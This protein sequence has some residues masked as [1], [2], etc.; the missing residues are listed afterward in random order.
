[1]KKTK[2]Y[3]KKTLSVFMAIMM[4][5]TAWVF[6]APEK[7]E[8]GSATT[9]AGTNTTKLQELNGLDFGTGFTTVSGNFHGDSA[10]ETA[11]KGIFKN[12]LY[13]PHFPASNN[14]LTNNDAGVYFGTLG[15]TADGARVWYPETT[16]IW[17]GVTTP[18]I[19]ILFDIDSNNKN[20]VGVK[21]V[22]I[23]S[24]ANGLSFKDAYW[25]AKSECAKDTNYYTHFTFNWIINNN[26]GNYW[27]STSSGNDK[28]SMCSSKGYWDIYATYLQYTGGSFGSGSTYYKDIKPTWV[29]RT[30]SNY[31]G[32]TNKTIYVIDYVPLKN[33]L[34]SV[35]GIINSINSNP[36][37]YTT[38]SV[39]AFVDAAK[40]LVAAK[41]NNYINAN[42]NNVYEWNTAVSNALSAWNSAK[43]LAVQ[44][45]TL[46]FRNADNQ[47]VHTQTSPYG[48]SVD[49][50]SIV[51]RLGT[52]IEQIAGNNAEHQTYKWD[53]SKFVSTITDDV[54]ISETPTGKVAHNYGDYTQTTENHSRTCSVCGYVFTQNHNEDKGTLDE[55]DTCTEAGRKSYD[56]TIC[57][58]TD[59]RTEVV[60]SIKGH[61]FS[62]AYLENAS[63]KDGTHWQECIRFD[64]CK[65]YGIGTTANKCEKHNWDKDNSGT[66][67]AGDAETKASTCNEAG[68]EMYTCKVCSATWTKV[69]P[70]ADHSITE[71]KAKD[72]SNICGADGYKAFWTC[73]VCDRVWED[74]DLSKEIL[75]PE[76]TVVDG[77]SVPKELVVKGP[78][79][80]FIGAYVSVK[81]G[82]D[83]KH[84]RQCERFTQC[85][86]YG[87]EE[88][89]KFVPTVT[90]STCIKAGKTTYTCSDC[91]SKYEVAL[92]LA[93]HDMTK[94]DAV[95]AECGK[96]GSIEYYNCSVC[97][98][99]YSDA[100]GKNEVNNITVPAL[101]H[102]FL[103]ENDII[104]TEAELLVS[105]ATCQKAAVYKAKCDHCGTVS[106]DK[107]YSVGDPDTVN[108]HKFDGAI[109]KNT[110]GTHSYKCTVAGCDEYGAA[111]TC[112]FK[113][114]K[115]KVKSTC[116]TLGYTI[117]E[118]TT[119]KAE[120]RVD[121]KALDFTNH[122]GE[123]EIRAAVEAKCN[124]NG[125]TGDTYCLGCG[126]MIKKGEAIIAD[127]T[128]HPHV[129]MKDYE[130]KPSTCQDA[131]Y[132]AYK[133]CD[134]CRTYEIEKV[135][136]TL[137][138]HKFTKYVT[139]NDG[140][141]TAV[142]DTCDAEVAEP[143]TDT[144]DC[145]GGTANCVDKKVCTVCNAPYGEV[146]ATNHKTVKTAEK[147]E[148]TCQ[149]E[150]TV[151]YRYCEACKV[152]IEKPETIAKKPHIFGAWSKIEGEDKHTRSCTTCVD[153][154]KLDIATETKDC[155]G[156]TAYCNALAKCKDCKAEYG[157]LDA[158][159]H[160][161][162]ANYLDGAY[163]A[164]CQKEGFTGNYL[165]ECCNALKQ[166]GTT[167]PKKDHVFDIEVENSR[168]DATCIAEGEVTYKCSTCVETADVKAATDKKVLPVN[169]NNH[170]TPDETVVVGKKAA[171]C[172]ED[173]HTGDVYYK[174]C[175]KEGATD[176]ENRKALKEKGTT[177][178]ANGQHVYGEAIP[179]YMIER[180]DETKDADGNVTSR[181]IV[182]KTK[183]PDYDA[184]VDARRADDKWY[185]F[186]QCTICGVITETACYTY[187]HTYN[188]VDTDKCEVCKGLCSLKDA[189][190][191]I[192]LIK[193]DQVDATHT[194]DGTKAYYQCKGCK[195]YFL[196]EAGKNE[197]NPATEEG[198]ALIA[199]SKDTV[200]CSK[201]EEIKSEYVAPTCGKDG[202]KVYS[203]SIEGCTKTIVEV[204]PAT[205][206]SHEWGTEYE[207]IKAP[208]CG[209]VGYEALYCT[210]CDAIK[211][212]STVTI[213][214]T[215]EH[216]F[217]LESKVEG[218]SCK[219]PSIETYKCETCGKTKTETV[220]DGAAD[221]TWSDWVTIGGDCASGIIQERECT[222]CGEKER[223]SESTDAHIY[224]LVLR[225][226]PTAEKDGYEIYKCANCEIE[227]R[228]EIPYEG[229]T[230]EA[231]EDK[232]IV[233]EEKYVVVK[234][235]DCEHGEIRRYVCLSCGE[236]VEKEVGEPAEHVWLHQNAE[237]A[238]CTADGHRE[239]YRCVRCLAVYEDG[240]GD[241][242]I[243]KLGHNDKDK[244]GKC[245]RCN[246][247]FY[248]EG[249][250]GCICHK[251]NGFM[252]LIYKILRFF[253]KLFGIGHSCDCGAVHY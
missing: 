2:T 186:E 201:G 17:D 135:P 212:N 239:Y 235:A 19:G 208:T 240:K 233:N 124:S 118:C 84:H 100:E 248:S 93:A 14:N 225:V 47:V 149:T 1:M 206:S 131:G 160:K 202:K 92:P 18:Q 12:T 176:A 6:V 121:E 189:D 179:E 133:Y 168:V 246:A 142:C 83:G 73:S 42:N 77:V 103:G 232:H 150:G 96:A 40:K 117:Y 165:Y 109:R 66:V 214:A 13:S 31:T 145:T 190:K 112:D 141:H 230:P 185:H 196:D 138:A 127:P 71:T 90:P 24:G 161:T 249:E 62:G 23:S 123:T 216:S 159:N 210:K 52:T 82:A 39:S 180:I 32:T 106:A 163:D 114:V 238:T 104:E 219:D 175:Y 94:Y 65:T 215:G 63:G 64:E 50:N 88:A 21:N 46:E 136:G 9:I 130:A 128:V 200:P 122:E 188:C 243:E 110:D 169:A 38:A 11:S 155:T 140:T 157:S 221:H 137:K 76:Y 172:E 56:C 43:N 198:K 143:A 134:Q 178:K 220:F 36:A 183:A 218:S 59:I 70:L 60:D 115:A 119:C 10:S 164:T 244:D 213:A 197:F 253:W 242:K 153:T 132:S 89:H 192:E 25:T 204:V 193:I 158:A 113:N 237:M 30:G 51:N 99:N 152:N 162:Q 126:D 207:E 111:T 205:D 45:Y 29:C 35:Q 250:C 139:N 125:Y 211:P 217:K 170:A 229:E 108:G 227:Y 187:K 44:S 74:V 26:A 67:D 166:A 81:D 129:N 167:I 194:V 116:K 4:L 156:G 80:N 57:G 199:I 20:R 101:T 33:A 87:P 251:E 3:A 102:S 16:L 144:K 28:E 203:C 247:A 5:M 236:T 95:P 241:I 61:E 222:F 107:V 154:D 97:K 37:K 91:N 147:V 8:A 78:A 148:P 54:T 209:S 55:A 7:A 181:T 173:G 68:Y 27:I 184:M 98:K 49:C 245:D 41:P 177:I 34:S 53:D 191:H 228:K 174:C 223:K 252:Q 48:T 22:Y 86:T 15:N 231:P 146:D 75:N 69:L 195:K 120:N 85:G 79:H 224:E 105:A 234:A 58:M 171:T 151:A 182:L 72:V 226:E